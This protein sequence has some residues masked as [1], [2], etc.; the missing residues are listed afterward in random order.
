MSPRGLCSFP[1]SAAGQETRQTARRDRLWLHWV[2][3]PPP[4]LP[5]PL[6]AAAAAREC[7]TLLLRCRCDEQILPAV[8]NWVG[9][10][11][12]A[13]PTQLGTITLGRA[14]MQA[15][16]SPLG[17]IAGVALLHPPFLLHISLATLLAA[18][19]CCTPAL[20]PINNFCLDPRH[21]G[22]FMSRGTVIA[23]GCWLWAAMTAVF[24]CTTSLYIAM[25]V[26]AINGVG[27]SLAATASQCQ[28]CSDVSW[29]MRAGSTGTGTRMVCM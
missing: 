27:A 2:G 17:G 9:A 15:L 13:T 14:M 6:A 28:C 7:H 1:D 10:S 19:A 24:A 20:P 29:N 21:A 5:C 26:C 22:H 25:P 16:S 8:Y 3:S 18:P 11:F 4:A 12:N 23:I